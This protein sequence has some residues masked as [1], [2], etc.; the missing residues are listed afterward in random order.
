MTCAWW[1]WWVCMGLAA[2]VFVCW[3]IA[4]MHAFGERCPEAERRRRG[5]A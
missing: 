2:L 3:C 1:P 4:R 5:R